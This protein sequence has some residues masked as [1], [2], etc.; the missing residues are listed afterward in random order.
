MELQ[1]EDSQSVSEDGKTPV[2]PSLLTPLRLHD[3]ALNN[4][5]SCLTLQFRHKTTIIMFRS[6]VYRGGRSTYI[7]LHDVPDILHAGSAAQVNEH[8][9]HVHSLSGGA[10]QHSAPD[11][12]A[13]VKTQ[14]KVQTALTVAYANNHHPV[15]DDLLFPAQPTCAICRQSVKNTPTLLFSSLPAADVIHLLQK[16][17]HRRTRFA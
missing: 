8:A 10:C 6:S 11:C 13:Y 4:Q 17:I 16:Q 5:A 14:K 1:E 7:L 2:T 3:L 15:G 12:F 9:K